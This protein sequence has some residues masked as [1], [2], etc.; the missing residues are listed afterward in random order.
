MTYLK[1]NST[2]TPQFLQKYEVLDG[3][4]IGE[5]SET[6]SQEGGRPLNENG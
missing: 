6:F 1:T 2:A 4:P 3:V 5:G